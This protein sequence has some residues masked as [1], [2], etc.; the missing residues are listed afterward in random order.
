VDPTSPD[1]HL[2][3]AV[4]LRKLKQF[5]A[6]GHKAILIIGDFTARIG[7][8]SGRESERKPLSAKEVKNNLKK[9]LKLAGK[10]IDIKKAEIVYN[11]KWFSKN[12][13]EILMELSGAISVQQVL[14]RADF[15]E[16]IAKGNE[17]T[18]REELYPLLQGFDSV[19]VK[20]DVE[21]GGTDQKFNLL[22]GRRIQR[23]FD[24]PEQDIMTMDLLEG[25]DG[26]KKMSKSFGNYIALDESPA[27]MFG[28]LMSI[29]DNLLKKYFILLTS[30]D[31]SK[32]DKKPPYEQ[33]K[34][35]A[36]EVVSF[37]HSRRAAEKAGEYFK[38]T[39]SKK[40]VPENPEIYIARH[41]EKWVEFL[42]RTNLVF[43]NGEAR[44][45]LKGRGV[46]F[47]GKKVLVGETIKEKGVAKIGKHRFIKIK[48]N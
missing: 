7:D 5:Q 6:V 16:R 10:I 13:L 38:K 47:N 8:P 36:E 40:E 43:S 24:Q 27:E 21:I 48:L 26:I 28:K 23:Y 20:A 11:S 1:L 29:P 4:A 35:L 34:R 19:K 22:M 32:L 15:Q 25:T 2:G 44:R 18:I 30:L 12:G 45:L 14:K 9:Y 3:H 33:K 37:F 39:F 41:G 42:A 31:Y 46:D 17:I